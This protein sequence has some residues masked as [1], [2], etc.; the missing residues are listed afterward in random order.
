M[1]EWH[2]AG[3]LSGMVAIIPKRTKREIQHEIREMNK[4]AK[5][6]NKSPATA[7]KFL[8]ENGFIT[9]ENKLSAHYR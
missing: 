9:K 4:A 2:A 8:R 6:I 1:R 7:R 5:Q 3:L